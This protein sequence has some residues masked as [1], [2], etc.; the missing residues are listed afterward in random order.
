MPST[1]A[2]ASGQS[3]H[4]MRVC[5]FIPSES[6]RYFH[7]CGEIRYSLALLYPAIPFSKKMLKSTLT[8]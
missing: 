4:R 1:H 7:Q 6:R 5:L 8:F 3:S 2:S